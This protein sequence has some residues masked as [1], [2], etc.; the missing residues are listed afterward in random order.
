MLILLLPIESESNMVPVVHFEMPD[1]K[2]LAIKIDEF[3]QAMK[4]YEKYAFYNKAGL[5]I[6]TLV[7]SLQ[8]VTFFKLII[9]YHPIPILYLILAFISATILTDLVSGL[10]H[11]VM[12]NNTNYKSLFGPFVASFHLHH[13]KPLYKNQNPWKVYYDESGTKFWL[14]IYL[15]VVFYFQFNTKLPFFINFFLV[16]FGILSSIAELSHY[17]CHNSREDQFIISALQ[18]YRLLLSKTHHAHHHRSDNINYAFLNGIT[19][20]I[21]NKMASYLYEGYK[22]NS[23][24]HVLAYSGIQTSNR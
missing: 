15:L 11:M 22:N 5:L 12:D 1:E 2:S 24:K 4:R 8:A 17:W 3:D 14:V 13:K 7:V 23:D 10:V 16:T 21:I 20:P 19:N 18:K 6:S 9:S